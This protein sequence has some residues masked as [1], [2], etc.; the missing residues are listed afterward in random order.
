MYMDQWVRSTS[1]NQEK[2]VTCSTS[3][4]PLLGL[5]RRCLVGLHLSDMSTDLSDM[6]TDSLVLHAETARPRFT[7]PGVPLRVLGAANLVEHD[8]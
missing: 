5:H 6:S 2:T 1:H 3:L 4:A 8:S 7:I